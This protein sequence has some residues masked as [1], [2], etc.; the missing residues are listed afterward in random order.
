M[1]TVIEIDFKTQRQLWKDKVQI[2]ED[3][4]FDKA[5]EYGFKCNTEEDCEKI[6]TWPEKSIGAVKDQALAWKILHY[7]CF[8]AEVIKENRVSSWKTN[9]KKICAPHQVRDQRVAPQGRKFKDLVLDQKPS[10]NEEELLFN[11]DAHH[12]RQKEY[13]SKMKKEKLEKENAILKHQEDILELQ[14]Q[15][16][17]LNAR[18]QQYEP[19]V[20]NEHQV[21]GG[22][23]QGELS[24]YQDEEQETVLEKQP[25]PKKRGRKPK[26]KVEQLVEQFETKETESHEI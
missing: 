14:I 17:N 16:E 7:L 20:A 24:D 13:I 12:R 19:M 25:S 5:A 6:Q 8:T 1:Q 23:D 11:Y 18:L 9:W 3:E 4:E 21:A 26:N 2:E 15:L 10:V 22:V